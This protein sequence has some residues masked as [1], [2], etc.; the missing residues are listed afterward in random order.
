MLS[1]T[2]TVGQYH[3]SLFTLQKNCS[4]ECHPYQFNSKFPQVWNHDCRGKALDIEK[5][6][7]IDR[8]Y[9]A[10]REPVRSDFS[11]DTPTRYETCGVIYGGVV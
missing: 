9:S 6:T 5:M 7:V 8:N 10:I 2:V 1:M 3:A 11:R 4:D